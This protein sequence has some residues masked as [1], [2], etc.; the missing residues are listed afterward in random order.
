ME[1]WNPLGWLLLVGGFLCGVV[2]GWVHIADRL[3]LLS[4]GIMLAGL[5]ILVMNMTRSVWRFIRGRAAIRG[6]LK[7]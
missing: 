6:R 5:T 3:W 4:Y 7:I 1:N 2:L